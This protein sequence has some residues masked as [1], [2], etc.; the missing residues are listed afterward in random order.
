M[1][2][3]DSGKEDNIRQK[4]IEMIVKEG[5][6]GFGIN[7]LAKAA[8]VSPATIYIYFNDKEHL[9]STLC[10]DAGRALIEYSLK[11]FSGDMSF[12]E[13]L[14]I[15]WKNRMAYFMKH[16]ADMEFLEIMRYTEYYEQVSRM[17]SKDFGAVMAQ[18]MNNAIAK[19]QL[20]KL[21]FEVYWALAF[22]PMYQLIKFHTQGKSY[23]NN[24]FKL[25]EE[26]LMQ[27]L[28][29]VLKGLKP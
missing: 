16:P 21:P 15:Q 9:I 27:A 5:L 23:M 26:A 14:R 12:D 10:L 25:T 2:I 3:K 1:R 8:D 29:V 18:F 24:S 22:A 28:N 6:Q 11:D 7:K 17:M 13:G 4:A 20:V 19:K